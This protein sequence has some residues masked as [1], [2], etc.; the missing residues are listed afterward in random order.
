MNIRKRKIVDLPMVYVTAELDLGGKRYLAAVSE[1]RGEKAYIIDP[2]T[3]QYAELWHGDTGVMN[4]IQIP[5]R[6]Q[7]LAITRFYPVFQSREANI[8]LLEPTSKGYM[9]PW[10]IREVM[11]LPFCH[12]IGIVKNAN[13]LFVIACQLCQD[14]DFQDDWSKPGAIW[15]API[16]EKNDDEWKLTKLFDGL[17]KNHGL[18]ISDDNQ[19]YI[20]SDNG[21]LLF[22]L[23]A[24]HVGD[25]AFPRLL[26]TTPTSD[27]A[28]A[29]VDKHK[30]L[31]TIEPFHGDSAVLYSVEDGRVVQLSRYD[32]NFGHVVWVG[33][34]FGK[35]SMIAG[36]R[37]GEKQLEIIDV[38][39]GVRTAIETDVGPTQITV[40][41]ENS[42]CKV[43]AANHGA[44]EVTLY[45][46]EEE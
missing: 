3:C 33:Q 43:F 29:K 41:E 26:T 28:V 23:S 4:V 39:S 44:G 27:I 18:F 45:S 12:R 20:G 2:E 34:L 14:K 10:N 13:G 8:C 31:S 21:V 19:V 37:S 9:H 36:S 42:T 16:P 32:I 30:Y 5:G 7:L 22:D 1:A 24:Y 11:P 15:M 17:T 40:Y 6:D 46:L 35:L 25:A 38:V